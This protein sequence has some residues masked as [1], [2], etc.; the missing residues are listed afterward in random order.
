M[1]LRALYSGD[2]LVLYPG[3]VIYPSEHWTYP[4]RWTCKNGLA[5]MVDL[6][7]IQSIRFQVAR[8]V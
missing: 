6:L 5:W 7:L 2:I 3:R 4:I 1:D 8:L